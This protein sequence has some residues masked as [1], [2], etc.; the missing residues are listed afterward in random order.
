LPFAEIFQNAV[1][2]YAFLERGKGSDAAIRMLTQVRFKA[3]CDEKSKLERERADQDADEILEIEL[4]DE[5]VLGESTKSREKTSLKR[6][7]C[8]GDWPEDV[9][10][11]PAYWKH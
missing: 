2:T 3:A 9:S 1:L 6:R 10:R 4:E 8:L 5:T 7:I 11:V